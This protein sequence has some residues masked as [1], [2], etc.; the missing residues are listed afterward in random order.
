MEYKAILI[1]KALFPNYIAVFAFD[2]SSNHSAYCSNA[3]L[4]N[5]MNL[6]PERKQNKMRNTI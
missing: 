6:Q 2:N 3:L 4:A 1:F 5:Q